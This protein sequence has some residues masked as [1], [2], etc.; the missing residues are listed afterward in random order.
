[1]V[2][3]DVNNNGH[4]EKIEFNEFLIHIGVFLS[5]QELRTVYDQF[6]LNRDG[7]ISYAELIKVLR[8]TATESRHKAI[9]AAFLQ[10]AKNQTSIPLSNLMDQFRCECHPRVQSREKCAKACRHET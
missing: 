3:F 7:L 4:L 2:R 5:T 8:D 9:R 10:L 6:D 1:M